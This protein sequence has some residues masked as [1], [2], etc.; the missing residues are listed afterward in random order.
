VSKEVSAKADGGSANTANIISPHK[1]VEGCRK[2]LLNI[3]LEI[4]FE[5]DATAENVG[6]ILVGWRSMA[7]TPTGTACCSQLQSF[8][9]GG[10]RSGP[11]KKGE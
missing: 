7:V 9:A 3:D 1:A 5:P 10:G 2:L 6:L 4:F 8:S 11:E